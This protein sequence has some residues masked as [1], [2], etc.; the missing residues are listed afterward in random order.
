[1]TLVYQGELPG[2]GLI[3]AMPA[4]RVNPLFEM[5]MIMAHRCCEFLLLFVVS[6]SY[7]NLS[8]S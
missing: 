5:F 4:P 6:N 8:G 2:T 1:M 7:K 3:S